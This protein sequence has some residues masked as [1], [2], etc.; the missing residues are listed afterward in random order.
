MS[1][2]INMDVYTEVLILAVWN[3]KLIWEYGNFNFILHREHTASQLRRKIN[4]T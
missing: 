3:M 2:K 4:D 1:E